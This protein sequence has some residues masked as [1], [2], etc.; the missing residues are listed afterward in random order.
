MLFIFAN[1]L[2]IRSMNNKYTGNF[3]FYTDLNI[4][5]NIGPTFNNHLAKKASVDFLN[6][7]AIW[8]L[9]FSVKSQS[10]YCWKGIPG[11]RSIGHRRYG[12]KK[13]IFPCQD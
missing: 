9:M 8:K 4:K 3:L 12:S 10:P 2:L 7:S 5:H 11:A 1:S 13:Y 6:F